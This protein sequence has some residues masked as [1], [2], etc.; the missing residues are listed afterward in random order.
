MKQVL[1]LIFPFLLVGSV[2]AQSPTP[3]SPLK[4]GYKASADNVQSK[5]TELR[6]I[7]QLGEWSEVESSVRRN[8]ANVETKIQELDLG[9]QSIYNQ[10][11][12]LQA[13]NNIIELQA[14]LDAL[15]EGRKKILQTTEQQLQ[16]INFRGLYLGICADID[17]F[18]PEKEHLQKMREALAPVAIAALNGAFI[19]SITELQNYKLEYDYIREKVSGSMEPMGSEYE[20]RNFSAGY[21]L[22]VRQERVFPL[23]QRV[24][25]NGTN[26]GTPNNV[27]IIDL[28]NNTAYE[29]EL[30]FIKDA[31]LRNRVSQFLANRRSELVADILRYNKTMRDKEALIVQ[32]AKEKL[33]DQDKRI[34]A[35]EK[36]LND[37][38][39]NAKNI[40]KE[41]GVTFNVNNLKGC[42]GEAEKI[43][44]GKLNNINAEKTAVK[45]NEL[46]AQLFD[47]AAQSGIPAQDLAQNAVT[48]IGVINQ[49][50]SELKGFLRE[51]SLK[52]G[53]IESYNQANATDV[54]REVD[55]Y[56]VYTIPNGGSFKLGV[57]AKF[58]IVGK[59][60]S[61]IPVVTP[62]QPVKEPVKTPST[63]AP[64]PRPRFDLQG[65]GNGSTTVFD[66]AANPE[67]VYV[68]GGTFSMGDVFGD[69]TGDEKPAHSV[70]IPAFYIGKYEV[71]IGEFA[72]FV[73]E[74]NYVTEAEKNGRT[75]NWRHDEQGNLRPASASNFPVMYVSWYDAVAYCQWLSSKSPF[76]FR[77]PTEAEWEYAARNRG[78]KSKWAGTSSIYE[79][80]LYANFIEGDSYKY[81][82][83]VGSF[84]A[85]ELGVFDM[86]GNVAEWCSDWHSASYY[87]SEFF[88]AGTANNPQGP[89]NGSSKVVRGGSASSHPEYA[90][91]VTRSRNQPNYTNG[92]VGFRIARNAI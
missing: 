27:K 51:I 36:E 88:R 87:Q 34:K 23:Q 47:V 49:S 25:S 79:T 63:P 11:K 6:K 45:S 56:W 54:F 43:L 58:K 9:A 21:F 42:L 2:V 13:A 77:L 22:Q 32:E 37:N 52:N 20:D 24:S 75:K 46:I 41:I 83:P 8:N 19:E 72:T 92:D 44:T 74:T 17:P 33:D 40:L 35:A 84:S 91:T 5:I 38:M 60:A 89:L 18:A 68:E 14:N 15:K 61:T 3:E 90:K 59:N 29:S 86:S 82:A 85:N 55:N 31:D 28:V 65:G 62:T 30:S 39:E 1:R 70:A 4:F 78:Q 16:A 10:L 73:Q 26:V 71:T 53:M 48:K 67:M 76:T 12:K 50:N 81:T 80:K 7:Y 66:K 69:G 57:V 64:R